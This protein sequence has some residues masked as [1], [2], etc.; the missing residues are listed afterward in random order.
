MALDS[1]TFFEVHLGGG[2]DARE[3]K[4]SQSKGS[5]PS[6]EQSRS[7]QQS[8]GSGGVPIKGLLALAVVVA[9]AGFAVKRF[10]GGGGSEIETEPVEPGVE[11]ERSEA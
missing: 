4:H 9:G 3:G 1:V 8:G 5:Q 7:G 6:G 10:L 11:V 2:S